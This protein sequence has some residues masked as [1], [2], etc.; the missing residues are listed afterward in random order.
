M[1]AAGFQAHSNTTHLDQPIIEYGKEF[2]LGFK[3]GFH[4]LTIRSERHGIKS[5]LS[6]HGHVDF[7]HPNTR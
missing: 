1:N 2:C 5:C 7:H 4:A 3:R 6:S